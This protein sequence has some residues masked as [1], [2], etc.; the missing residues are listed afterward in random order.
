[1]PPRRC[2]P[3]AE[4]D[5]N[6]RVAPASRRSSGVSARRT[7]GTGANAVTISDSGAITLRAL[8]VLV[9][10]RAH[11]TS[12]PCR[13]GSRCRARG[14]ARCRR[15]AR[16]RRAARPRPG[17]R[18]RPSSWRRACTSRQRVDRRR[19]EVGERLAD[20]HA[21]RG[22]RVEQRERRALAHRHRLAGVAVVARGG[23]RRVGD[24]HLPRARP[25]DRARPGP[26]TVRSPMV[27]R[28]VLSATVGSRSTRATA[29]PSSTCARSK[30]VRL[31]R[32]A[33][34]VARI[35]GGLPSSTSSGMSIGVFAEVR[36]VDAQ[37]AVVGGACRAPR[38]GSAR[39]RTAPRSAR[40]LGRDGRA[41]SAPAPR[42]TRSR[43]ATCPARRWAPRAARSA[44]RARS[45]APARAARCDSPPAPTSWIDA[46][47]LSSPSAQQRS[48]TSWQRR[49]ISA[50]SRCTEAKSRSSLDA[51]EASDEAAPPPRPISIAGPPSTMSGAPAGDAL[52]LHV[53]A[54]GCCRG[55]PRS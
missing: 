53:L 18:R 13:P 50:L 48:I 31:R 2:L 3:R 25:S 11:A 4:I 40:A 10:H 6:S 36:V 32:R 44:R 49:S 37:P 45:R 38:T 33:R 20:G 7:S 30:R 29:S 24:R 42:C 46:I 41:R 43:A 5:E 35:C 34:D 52:L 27:I 26:P 39:A 21:R 19:G 12:S 17:D 51:P 8:A 16:R 1:M 22:R 54:R 14:T 47:G 9:P 28:K 15:R 23:D 55:R